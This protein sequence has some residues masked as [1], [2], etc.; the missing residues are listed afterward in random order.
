MEANCPQQVA[1]P[2][3]RN[4]LDEL[5]QP[6]VTTGDGLGSAVLDRLGQ[7]LCGMQGHEHMLRHTEGRMF[8]QCVACGHESPGWDVPTRLRA[9]KVITPR[10]EATPPPPLPV[11][12][13]A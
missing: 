13:V 5:G 8:L 12:Q 9:A 7:M 6:L 3:E 4:P 11:R 10:A 1:A 2:G